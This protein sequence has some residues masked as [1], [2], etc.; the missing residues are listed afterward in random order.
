MNTIDVNV[1]GVCSTT[2]AT[3]RV[4]GAS[5]VAGALYTAQQII[6]DHP[7]IDAAD[8]VKLECQGV[9]YSKF[10]FS[11][12]IWSDYLGKEYY[13]DG[14]VLAENPLIARNVAQV[15]ASAII[16][17][18]ESKSYKLKLVGISLQPVVEVVI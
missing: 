12:Q 5:D 8:I 4:T 1:I 6:Q 11:I 7:Q 15:Q 18:V 10:I 9:I 13:V 2:L 17:N 14:Y 3:V 16:D